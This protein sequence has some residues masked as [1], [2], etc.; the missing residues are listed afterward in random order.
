MKL[1]LYVMLELC[2][3]L[4]VAARQMD[5]HDPRALRQKRY[6]D[7]TPK[8]RIFVSVCCGRTWGSNLTQPVIFP[9]QVP[10]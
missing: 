4:L 10:R 9:I 6:L 3:T 8:S 2:S 1:I 7:F 5:G